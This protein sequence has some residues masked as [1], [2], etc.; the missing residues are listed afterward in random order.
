MTKKCTIQRDYINSLWLIHVS[1]HP[2][3]VGETS[4]WRR[5]ADGRAWHDEVV[6]IFT[7]SMALSA[8]SYYFVGLYV[9]L[10]CMPSPIRG[11]GPEAWDAG[12]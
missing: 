8:H 3:S 9:M 7:A 12:D 1:K 2:P 6:C 5:A 10:R 11:L 4:H